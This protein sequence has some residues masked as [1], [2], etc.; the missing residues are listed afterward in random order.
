MD[1]DEIEQIGVVF[2]EVF[3]WFDDVLFDLMI[4]VVFF[5]FGVK[6]FVC[7][8]EVV[9]LFGFWCDGDCFWLRDSMNKDGG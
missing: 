2:E 6:D 5:G 8:D 4:D 3:V 9:E 7:F 1:V